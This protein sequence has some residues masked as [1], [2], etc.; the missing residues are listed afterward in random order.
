MTTHRQ[1]THMFVSSDQ[2]F[3]LIHITASLTFPLRWFPEISIETGLKITSCFSYSPFLSTTP[4][5]QT[6]PSSNVF[7]LSWWKLSL[8]C[9]MNQKPS[10]NLWHIPLFHPHIQSC[11]KSQPLLRPAKYSCICSLLFISDAT[12][13][14]PDIIFSHLVWTIANLLISTST[15]TFISQ[16]DIQPAGRVIGLIYKSEHTTHCTNP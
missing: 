8:C 11:R 10:S 2:N 13:L 5:N 4:F 3:A 6:W 15:C 16:F 12:T 14:V 9:S 7:C 1:L